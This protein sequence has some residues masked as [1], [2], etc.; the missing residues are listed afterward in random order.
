MQILFFNTILK[1][2]K[3]YFLKV[4]YNVESEAIINK[5]FVLCSV[6]TRWST[7]YVEWIFYPLM[8]LYCHASVI[9][10]FCSL[11]SQISKSWHISLYNIKHSLPISSEKHSGS[12]QA[13]SDS[14]KYKFS[15]I[16]TFPRSL[17]LATNIVFL[18]AIGS[19]GF[20]SHSFIFDKTSLYI[21]A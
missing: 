8:T 9:W 15:K 12:C 13:H 16:L 4:N 17:G 1:L 3:W 11:S 10:K 18:Q 5:L 19:F 20:F 7:L 2:D 21:Q 14:G 6:K